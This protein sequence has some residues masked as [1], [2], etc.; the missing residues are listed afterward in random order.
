[1]KFYL[2]ECVH[3]GG[4]EHNE[5]H[6]RDGRCGRVKRMWVEQG[7]SFE[8]RAMSEQQIEAAKALLQQYVSENIDEMLNDP[9]RMTIYVGTAVK[10]VARALEAKS[11]ALGSNLRPRP[12]CAFCDEPG[13]YLCAQSEDQGETI[14]WVVACDSHGEGWNEVSDWVAPV[15]RLAGPGEENPLVRGL[16]GANEKDPSV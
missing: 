16:Y 6:H 2:D 3:C 10:A 1:M 4:Q 7:T 12:E 8:N 15:Y 11:I 14:D 13:T 9:R 5:A